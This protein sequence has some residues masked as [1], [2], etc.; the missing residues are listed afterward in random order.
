M[1]LSEMVAG[2]VKTT[3]EWLACGA[4][5]VSPEQYKERAQ[6]C[7]DCEFF[8]PEAFAGKGRCTKCGCS[9]VKLYLATA[10]CPIDKWKPEKAPR[11]NSIS[12][13]L[14]RCRDRKKK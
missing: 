11:P 13:M 4:P 12:D 14:K 7:L 9:G 10:A 2:F 5:V 6:L 8:D 1:K 3:A